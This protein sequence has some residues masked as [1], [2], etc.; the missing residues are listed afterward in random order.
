[1]SKLFNSRSLESKFECSSKSGGVNVGSHT[2][3]SKLC[4]FNIL[5]KSFSISLISLSV[6]NKYN[7]SLVIIDFRLVL[8]YI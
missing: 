2:L 4:G 6:Y 3:I 5:I 8:L 1:M 7:S